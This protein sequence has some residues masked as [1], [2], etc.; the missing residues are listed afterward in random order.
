MELAASIIL[1]VYMKI[2]VIGASGL[3]GNALF[4]AFAS[5]H[6]IIG[7]FSAHP[8]GNLIR[9]DITNKAEVEGIFRRFMPDVVLLS[10]GLTNVELCEERQD[11]CQ[12]IN[13]E[14]TKNVVECIANL[15][16]KL[17]FFSSDY[18]FDGR[19]GPYSETDT[20][21][22]INVY[23]LA[24]LEAETLIRNELKNYLIIRSTVIYG[25]EPQAKNFIM[26][27][28]KNVELGKEM[29]VPNDQIGTPTYAINLA[30]IVKELVERNKIGIYNVAGCDPVSR[31]DFALVAA[32]VFGLNKRLIVPVSTVEL[33][34][35][36]KRPLR[37]GLKIDKVCRE[38]ST[39]PV[40]AREGLELMKNEK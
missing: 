17:V 20:P 7:T 34:Q 6:E 27:L 38:V 39:E 1:G 9:L 32:D 24:K 10:A 5:K 26:S 15:P 4:R 30:E 18:I 16:A 31:Y 35:R 8:I 12:K 40:G 23:G 22:P 36:A 2:L 25:W 21:N 3:V 29:R 33:N 11:L 19:N 14:G 13:V 37:A 28:L